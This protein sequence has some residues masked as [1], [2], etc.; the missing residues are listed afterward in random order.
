MAAAREQG[1]EGGAPRSAADDGDPHRP[2]TSPAARARVPARGGRLSGGRRRRR[3]VVEV[4][5]AVDHE[6]QV[7]EGARAEALDERLEVVEA[8]GTPR[9]EEDHEP[10]D[11]RDGVAGVPEELREDQRRDRE[12]HPEEGRQAAEALL[13]L[14][15]QLRL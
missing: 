4:R 5:V 1:G 9:G 8:V 13:P 6:A 12:Q 14:D 15:G 2:A 3:R 7:A 11:E 10:L